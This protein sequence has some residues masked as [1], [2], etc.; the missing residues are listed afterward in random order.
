MRKLF[1]NTILPILFI[2]GLTIYGITVGNMYY[3]NFSKNT[4]YADSLED[5]PSPIETGPDVS[6]MFN[7]RGFY[8]SNSVS[9]DENE[10]I[11]D[12]N[13]NLMYAFPMFNSK[14]KGDLY[15]DFKL[16]YNGSV[17]YQAMVGDSNDIGQAGGNIGKHNFTAP[18]WI[19]SLNGIGVQMINFERRFFTNSPDT[20][21]SDEDVHLLATGYHITDRQDFSDGSENF[22]D[23]IMIMQG[24]GSVLTLKKFAPADVSGEEDNYIGEYYTENRGEYTRAIVKYIGEGNYPVSRN[25]EVHLMRGDGLTYVFKE[26]RPEYED[27]LLNLTGSEEMQPQML[28]LT[29]VRDR[30]GH[31]IELT[32]QYSYSSNQP[33][34]GRPWL[35]RI[36]IP[37]GDN[38]QMYFSTINNEG[39]IVVSGKGQF[40][41]DTDGFSAYSSGNARPK[42]KRIINPQTDTLLVE[43]E[44]YE[45]HGIEA[46]YQNQL[47]NYI[48]LN[49]ELDRIS[50]IENFNGG[51]RS[52]TYK[53]NLEEYADLTPG[54]DLKIMVM[55]GETVKNTKFFGQGRDV[56]FS[57]MISSKFTIDNND[58]IK[59]EN[60]NYNFSTSRSYSSWGSNPVDPDDDCFTI[61]ETTPGS[62]G[63]QYESPGKFGTQ[64][65]YKNFGVGVTQIG[66]GNPDIEGHTKMVRELYYNTDT[67]SHYKKVDYY[68]IPGS[69]SSF[70]DT[71]ITETLDGIEFN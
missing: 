13:G 49:L 32:Y 15:L 6:G 51:I 69:T 27:F 67:N 61:S 47:G 34:Y 17:N 19:F 42:V 64:K 62:A 25:R 7:E 43:N 65:K 2:G 37:G 1:F 39:R 31:K 40:K 3:G 28:L 23:K 26:H 53:G 45:R 55:G 52:Y 38:I 9:V 11:S 14:G 30:F 35:S 21:A 8:K 22:R 63:N 24:D 18:G 33:I 46:P 20:A 57:N 66:E 4:A 5:N 29:E 70:P 50:R 12:F 59:Q 60:F 44:T 36:S 48:N 10:F 56:F 16:N 54:Q 71:L 58:T 41:I 68:F